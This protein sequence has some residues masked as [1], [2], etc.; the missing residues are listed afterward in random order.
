MVL[1][2]TSWWA[3]GRHVGQ[4]HRTVYC[5]LDVYSLQRDIN[6]SRDITHPLLYICTRHHVRGGRRVALVCKLSCWVRGGGELW[7]S[8]IPWSLTTTLCGKHDAA[9][10]FMWF[11]LVCLFV[12][13]HACQGT[14]KA[15]LSACLPA[16]LPVCLPVCIPPC[17]PACLH[18]S[19]SACL[20]AYL[21][22]QIYLL[23]T[24]TFS[25]P[26]RLSTVTLCIWSVHL[27]CTLAYACLYTFTLVLSGCPSF[28]LTLWLVAVPCGESTLTWLDY[29]ASRAAVRNSPICDNY[30]DSLKMLSHRIVAVY[31]VALYSIYTSTLLLWQLH[32]SSESLQFFVFICMTQNSL[33]LCRCSAGLKVSR[34]PLWRLV[35][36]LQHPCQSVLGWEDWATMQCPDSF[37]FGVFIVHV[38]L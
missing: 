34:A 22:A 8:V 4:Y 35:A 23:T 31:L 27:Y 2:S 9:N 33:S 10:Q 29:T 6:N 13:W 30:R 32:F 19:L 24:S 25:L 26:T 37:L 11:R 38:E 18:T 17:L 28:L 14:V 5:S 12:C 1:Y 20:S 15:C 36:P 3:Y 7:C 16:Y 21:P